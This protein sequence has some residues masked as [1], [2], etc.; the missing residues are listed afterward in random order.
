MSEVLKQLR[1]PFD[2]N[3]K[4]ADYDPS[5]KPRKLTK[6]SAAELLE[7]DILELTRLQDVFYAQSSH[8]MLLIFQALDAAGKDSTIKHVMSGVNPQ[9]VEV[10][11]FKAPSA[12]ELKHDFLWRCLKRLPERGN[13]GI[14]NRS[15]Y[16]EVLVVRVHPEFL[17][18][19]HLPESGRSMSTFWHLRYNHIVNMEQYL[20]D[21]GVVIV[22]F[23]LHVSKDEQ[24]RRFLDRI[25]KTAKNWKFSDGDIKERQYWDQYMEAYDNM[26]RHTSTEWAPWY[27]IPADHKWFARFAVARII[28]SHLNE[29]DLKYPK[30]D[31]S[32]E[33]QLRTSRDLLKKEK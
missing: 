28:I 12:E 1:V 30:M 2:H 21:Q 8:S 25:E 10:S 3:F 16:E 26:L 24:K 14:F 20:A 33:A 13:I 19:Q 11:S 7:A 5:Y 9:G 18:A 27:V 32:H 4:L 23:F 22:K 6:A 31:K 29:L 17:Q 15:Y